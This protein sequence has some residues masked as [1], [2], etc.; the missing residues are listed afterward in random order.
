V[1]R[2]VRVV[3]GPPYLEAGEPVERSLDDYA[4]VLMRKDPPFDLDYICA[5]YILSL[6]HCPVI[7]DPRGLR[8]TNEKLS[9]LAFPEWTPP[10]IATMSMA[11]ILAFVEEMGAAVVKPPGYMGGRDVFLLREGDPNLRALVESVTDRGRRYVVVQRYLPEIE[12]GDKRVLLWDGAV[13]GVVNRV[14]RPGELRGNFMAGGTAAPAELTDRERRLVAAV[15]ERLLAGGLRFVG[16]DL[17]GEHLT[18]INV[19]SP[20]GMR[21]VEKLTGESPARIM[22]ERLL[23]AL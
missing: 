4:C 1:A 20:T 3:V 11:K 19:T 8:D 6:V 16:L 2:P 14:P 9:V 21:E 12:A 22:M 23:A 17:I 10:T 18:E 15:G 5:T 7:N 13:I